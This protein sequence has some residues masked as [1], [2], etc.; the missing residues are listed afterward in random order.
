MFAFQPRLLDANSDTEI[1]KPIDA[2]AVITS[3]VYMDVSVNRESVGRIVIGLHGNVTPITCNKFEASCQHGLYAN[4][5]FH[6]I[7]PKFMI[8]GGDYSTIENGGG[9]STFKAKPFDDENFQ[10]KHTGPG[11]VSM[12]NAG[13]NTNSSQFFITT[14]RA[15]HLDGKHVVFGTVLQGWD[16][17]R[18]IEAVGTKSGKPT[19]VVRVEACGV[20]P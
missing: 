16:V 10:L 14:K 20:L 4:S 6:R 5:A 17:V 11:V 7:I 2:P 13:P 15:P 8:Q 12:A 3:K 19:R 9:A 18:K 1:T